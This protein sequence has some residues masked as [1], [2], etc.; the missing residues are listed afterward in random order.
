MATHARR[1]RGGGRGYLEAR[2]H[3]P[4]RC[5]G[6]SRMHGHSGPAA[7]NPTHPR[8]PIHSNAIPVGYRF[9][10]NDARAGREG[11]TVCRRR[12]TRRNSSAKTD[13]HRVGPG[14]RRH[15]GP[16]PLAGEREGRGGLRRSPKGD[17]SLLRLAH[18]GLGEGMT[19]WSEPLGGRCAEAAGGAAWP[20]AACTSTRTSPCAVRITTGATGDVATPPIPGRDSEKKKQA[21]P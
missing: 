13:R 9:K 2:A 20:P 1:T 5:A 17:A 7:P 8:V 10:K 18:L 16:S 15:R 4:T 11:S 14:A 3:P 12:R 21:R 19:A 6:N